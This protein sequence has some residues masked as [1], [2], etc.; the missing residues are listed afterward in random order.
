MELDISDS[1]V[2]CP[3][4]YISKESLTSFTLT[5][6]SLRKINFTF[7]Q[8]PSEEADTKAYEQLIS[9]DSL[10]SPEEA[11][12]FN[13]PHFSVSP[14]HG[15]L[16]PHSSLQ[17]VVTFKPDYEG[18]HETT[19]YCSTDS[20]QSPNVTSSFHKTSISDPHPRVAV[21]IFGSGIVPNISLSNSLLNLEKVTW[22]SSTQF[23][24][25]FMNPCPVDAELL[26]KSQGK[27]TESRDVFEL[28][29]FE[30][31]NFVVPAESGLVLSG[32]YC[33]S[34][35][36]NFET[37]H[38]WC[39]K[40]S[41][42]TVSLKVKGMVTSPSLKIDTD[43]IDFDFCSLGFPA[44]QSFT[45]T[46]SS[47]ITLNLDLSIKN[48]GSLLRKEFDLSDSIVTLQPNEF[49]KIKLKYLPQKEGIL[50]NML[51]IKSNNLSLLEVAIKGNVVVPMLEVNPGEL[52]IKDIFIR[53]TER[54]YFKIVNPNNLYSRFE[55][56]PPPK[57]LSNLNKL[58]FSTVSGVVPP[59]QSIL[60]DLD[61]TSFTRGIHSLCFYV[62]CSKS[63]GQAKSSDDVAEGQ[64]SDGLRFQV[65][66]TIE[67][68]GPLISV[69]QESISFGKIPVL[70]EYS[71]TLKITNSAPI[72]AKLSAY[73]EGKST[74]KTS[75]DPFLLSEQEFIIPP[76]TTSSLDI[77]ALISDPLPVSDLLVLTFE[78][79]DDINLP[80][81][82][83]GTGV[84]LYF[85]DLELVDCQSNVDFGHCFTNN[86][87]EYYLKAENRGSVNQTVSWTVKSNQSNDQSDSV[88]SISPAR[89]SL[90]PLHFQIFKIVG[91]SSTCQ[92][93]RS[94]L[95]CSSSST[96]NPPQVGLNLNLSADFIIPKVS[97][98][99]KTLDFTS[100][101]TFNIE[102]DGFPLLHLLLKFVNS[103]PIAISCRPTL[104]LI[105]GLGIN[106]SNEGF[107]ELQ[108]GQSIEFSIIFDPNQ[109]AVAK[110][111]IYISDFVY[112]LYQNHSR[113]DKIPL[114]IVIEFP[115]L[116]FENLNIDF[117]G[118]TPNIS[119]NRTQTVKNESNCELSAEF[120]LVSES[121][122]GLIPIHVREKGSVTESTNQKMIRA[123]DVFSISPFRFKLKPFEE[124][125][126][127]FSFLAP[128][129]GEYN[130]F[131]ICKIFGTAHQELNLTGF[132]GETGYHFDCQSVNLGKV[133][134]ND[135]IVKGVKFFNTGSLPIKFSIKSSQDEHF[136][137]LP[138][139]G[140]IRSGGS[141]NFS[142]KFK[143]KLPG[144]F[145][146]FFKICI[147]QFH[148]S[149]LYCHVSC[150]YPRVFTSLP[151]NNQI[152]DVTNPLDLIEKEACQSLTKLES[153]YGDELMGDPYF[154]IFYDL[155]FV[156]PKFG[157]DL[158]LNDMLV[159]AQMETSL[160]GHQIKSQA[161]SLFLLSYLIDFG[162]LAPGNDK[163]VEFLL[164]N[165]GFSPI[166]LNF[167]PKS[168]GH[169]AI[170]ISPERVTKLPVNDS[171]LLKASLN[172]R[173][174]LT[175]ESKS[176]QHS[177]HQ[178]RL[179]TRS[180]KES[181]FELDYEQIFGLTGNFRFS[182][183]FKA[184]VAPPTV[185][186]ESQ[187]IDFGSVSFGFGRELSEVVLVNSSN[188]PANFSFSINN[189][190]FDLID[191]PFQ[192]NLPRKKIIGNS[193]VPGFS[194]NPN[195]TPIIPS[196]SKVSLPFRFQPLLCG[197][198]KAVV[199]IKVNGVLI[200]DVDLIGR[201][202]SVEIS[203]D[204]DVI[205]Y[206]S[207]EQLPDEFPRQTIRVRNP[208]NQSIQ[209][210]F[211]NRKEELTE[212]ISDSAQPKFSELK[213]SPLEDK[214]EPEIKDEDL[215]EDDEN[216][217]NPNF[218]EEIIDDVE[219]SDY[220][221]ID[222]LVN[223]ATDPSIFKLTV[224]LSSFYLPE[225]PFFNVLVK[226]PNYVPPTKGKR[227]KSTELIHNSNKQEFIQVK[228][229]D[230][231]ANSEIE[232]LVNVDV[233]EVCNN[234]NSTINP[235]SFGKI[236]LFLKDFPV[237][238]VSV[239]LQAEILVDE[240]DSDPKELIEEESVPKG[241]NLEILADSLDF[242]RFLTR[243]SS[244][245]T[246]SIKNPIKSR[247]MVNF[248]PNEDI[249]SLLTF[250]KSLQLNPLE[251]KHIQLVFNS[252]EPIKFDSFLSIC[253][254]SEAILPFEQEYQVQ[255]MGEAFDLNV[256]ISLL[257]NS[258]NQEQSAISLIDFGH[259][260]VGETRLS[261]VSIKNQGLYS[262]SGKFTFK[263]QFKSFT[264][265]PGSFQL[266]SNESIDVY[267][268]FESRKIGKLSNS[269]FISLF[270][271]DLETG[272]AV[273][274]IDFNVSLNSTVP[275]YMIDNQHVDFGVNYPCST[276]T[277]EVKITNT[278]TVDFLISFSFNS[279]LND[280]FDIKPPEIT[281]PQSTKPKDKPK[282]ASK[283]KGN[284]RPPSRI[285]KEKVADNKS[286]VSLDGV[287][288]FNY[289]SFEDRT[290]LSDE[291]FSVSQSSVVLKP[292]QSE[293]FKIS[294]S[295]DT[296]VE[297]RSSKL[298]FKISHLQ[299]DFITLS[300]V[301]DIPKISSNPSD[302]SLKIPVFHSIPSKNL[303]SEFLFAEDNSIYFNP[304]LVNFKNQFSCFD[305]ISKFSLNST[306]SK[307]NLSLVNTSKVCAKIK[308][309]ITAEKTKSKGSD[310][311]VFNCQ[312]EPIIIDSQSVADFV[313]SFTPSLVGEFNGELV[314]NYV[315]EEKRF[316]QCQEL[317]TPPKFKLFGRCLSPKFQ[318]LYKDSPIQVGGKKPFEL[319]FPKISVSNSQ[320]SKLT[321]ESINEVPVIVSLRIRSKEGH[322][323]FSLGQNSE[324]TVINPLTSVDFS[325]VF[326]P[327]QEGTFSCEL[328]IVIHGTDETKILKLIGEAYNS[329]LFFENLTS[330]DDL[331]IG[332]LALGNSTEKS[333]NLVNKALK[334]IRYSIDNSSLRDNFFQTHPLNGHLL[335]RSK[336]SVSVVFHPEDTIQ[337]EKLPVSIKWSTI[338]LDDDYSFRSEHGPGWDSTLTEPKLMTKAQYDDII[339]G[340]EPK[341]KKERPKSRSKMIASSGQNPE[342]QSVHCFDVPIIEPHHSIVGKLTS[343][344]FYLTAAA[345]EGRYECSLS[346]SIRFKETMLFQ[347]RIFEFSIKNIS[348]ISL[349]FTWH[350]YDSNDREDAQYYTI[351][352]STGSI[353]PNSDCKFT[354][355]FCPTAMESSFLRNLVASIPNLALDCVPPVFSI[356][357]SAS[358]P[359]CYFDLS[360]LD[361]NSETF[362][363]VSAGK[364]GYHVIL[365][366]NK[367][368]TA[369]SASFYVMNPTETDY[370]FVWEFEKDGNSEIQ[371]QNKRGVIQKGRKSKMTFV[372]EPINRVGVVEKVF[373]FCI[374]KKEISEPFLVR[375]EAKG[376]LLK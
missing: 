247:V 195:Q 214:N 289:D 190:Q 71:K 3:E 220:D 215:V 69:D 152:N 33:S 203:L 144:I 107:F 95:I 233:N 22:S 18:D 116:V 102:S 252:H 196:H 75:V 229:I 97:I 59:N 104:P 150:L 224:P 194:L 135:T 366:E 199:S 241:Q 367:A 38:D 45:L 349:P 206:G 338:D 251:T 5:N 186:I 120:C 232:L 32:Q 52:I 105:P 138:K 212:L 50:D 117:G 19:L 303:H 1:L 25:R 68:S 291:I 365:I 282:S 89:V 197:S 250:P 319:S 139:F 83:R 182:L 127:N 91:V 296:P 185:T 93:S 348:K 43:L 308:P 341:K 153:F 90:E 225:T 60:I 176:R 16:Y 78:D 130:C 228:S 21:T 217:K 100:F 370:E 287:G 108:P 311:A 314:L 54:T 277:E 74:K 187:L 125:Q 244:R 121:N 143:S 51:V 88:F 267:V 258:Q 281:P 65:P 20:P 279:D 126:L 80:I 260:T 315:D 324:E 63:C 191:C 4:C 240:P 145:H 147:N 372:F 305:L 178:S 70:N 183:L 142:I 156:S 358:R 154:S 273:T 342:D 333:F 300:G 24:L 356:N 293:I 353:K 213:F 364:Q 12:L 98:S 31:E 218:E 37:V 219:L 174:L 256:A 318:I 86:P 226:N 131:V 158:D 81:S 122:D 39:I 164:T 188:I 368:T 257:G 276:V 373:K 284:S 357:G 280:K 235:K 231:E 112:I 354:L 44:S 77:L 23:E 210:V 283:K 352:P 343:L 374:P 265:T 239:D 312:S 286:L 15:T 159:R 227:S 290:E 73:L 246:L 222:D 172:T 11:S 111:G 211:P 322:N 96:K 278:S 53:K 316:S 275:S 249:E 236:G 344:D 58:E 9:N 335:P 361:Q 64:N 56:V 230:V 340:Q 149:V 6:T 26:S 106:P 79:A 110:K 35:L 216:L 85:P 14:L 339:S 103:C 2:Q 200:G 261:T 243:S 128:F 193:F 346:K 326:A 49:C 202:E 292:G 87:I 274:P 157:I 371:C 10:L 141:I 148:E 272:I 42:R 242:K 262:V 304:V 332:D 168:I 34:I 92:L 363:Q 269:P 360:P 179:S 123:S 295:S 61:V 362:Q 47:P 331:I 109:L 355:R 237:E 160:L 30:S 334:P 41:K 137:I 245:A 72:Q 369:N 84:S 221:V 67:S 259:V 375:G 376:N 255:L 189:H 285:E 46:N 345:D 313:V 184:I 155:P 347:T 323:P 114:N 132:A 115:N 328:E 66:V 40:G 180:I 310:G 192:P 350:F 177:R 294:F 238:P 28:L 299:L 234:F 317:L 266:G 118:C 307:I 129:L 254:S 48:D 298:Y 207:F 62:V 36:G 94:Q 302:L 209:L 166:S 163:T 204:R 99:Q 124:K 264:I 101:W 175:A 359:V 306:T 82:A 181:S 29:E 263:K 208:A 134:I 113:K 162:S 133:L 321:V 17:V 330:T 151:L 205:D 288:Q 201:S 327:Q 223:P 268:K 167:T 13:H 301:V 55:I 140:S 173:N 57:A 8:H 336:K 161:K 297:Q 248:T 169:S 27:S 170:T 198:Y 329:D 320:S 146:N 76:N 136:S 7:H 271:S 270:L 309:I 171:I 119:A 325:I 351:S 253:A 337:I 165:T